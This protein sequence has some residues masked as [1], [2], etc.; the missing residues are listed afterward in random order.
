MLRLSPGHPHVVTLGEHLEVL[1]RLREG[2]VVLAPDAQV[3]QRR[4]PVISNLPFHSFSRLN[5]HFVGCGDPPDLRITG[6][7]NPRYGAQTPA[8]N[9][10][11]RPKR[12]MNCGAMQRSLTHYPRQK[13]RNEGTEYGIHQIV[14]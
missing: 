2:G 12:G 11:R 6:G 1:M 5:Y 4:E 13:V 9:A 7:V 14:T 10:S 3:E 8:V